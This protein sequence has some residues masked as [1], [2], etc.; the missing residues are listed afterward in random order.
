MAKSINKYLDVGKISINVDKAASA[1]VQRLLDG[2]PKI[3]TKA[4]EKGSRNFGTKLRDLVKR[5]IFTGTPPS[6]VNWPPLSESTIH[7]LGKHPIYYYTGT[8]Y[9]AITFHNDGKRVWVGVGYNRAG[10]TRN[11]FNKSVA[12]KARNTEQKSKLTLNQIAIILEFGSSD[13]KI[14]KRP[15]WEPAWKQIGGNKGLQQAVRKEL[16]RELKNYI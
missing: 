3:Y 14:P 1:K 12:G 7:S 11:R 9:R 2:M 16:L 10:S 15:L 6:G 13:G 4:W 5:C 8:Y